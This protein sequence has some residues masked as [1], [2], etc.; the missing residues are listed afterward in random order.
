VGPVLR[1]RYS[2]IAKQ[3]VHA[4]REYRSTFHIRSGSALLSFHNSCTARRRAPLRLT[5][6]HCSFECVRERTRS[7]DL[8]FIKRLKKRGR[9]IHLPLELV[10]SSRRFENRSF[11]STFVR[12]S[13]L[14]ALYWIG[15]SP[16][17]LNKFYAA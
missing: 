9:M 10:A 1:Y 13:L 15:V 3:T 16:R 6:R 8:E 12:W 11:P 7:R 5:H 17:T 4:S 14:Q 2:D